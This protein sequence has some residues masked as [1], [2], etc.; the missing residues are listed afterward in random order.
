MFSLSVPVCC[1]KSQCGFN[2]GN[3]AGDIYVGGF[4]FIFID[5]GFF[6]WECSPEWLIKHLQVFVIFMRYRYITTC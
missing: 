4:L 2:T 1:D 5:G 3:L 6:L